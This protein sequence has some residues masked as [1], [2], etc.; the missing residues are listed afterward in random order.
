MTDRG[1][2]CPLF[3]RYQPEDLA[4]PAVLR[5]STLYVVGCLYGNTAALQTVV[6]R[7]ADEGATVMFNG[8]FH[9]LDTDPADFRLV[10]ETVA[11]H[12]AILGNV[13]AELLSEDDNGCGCAYPDY[14]DNATVELSNKIASTLALTAASTPESVDMLRG[15]PRFLVGE[16][17]GT[18]IGILHGDSESLAGWRLALEAAEPADQAIRGVGAWP[19]KPTTA[20]DVADWMTRAEV[21]VFACTHTGLPFAQDYDLPAGRRGFV[22]N[23]GRAGMPNFAGSNAGLM[24]RLSA[25]PNPPADSLYGATVEHLRLD[26]VPVS[27]DAE[28]WEHQFL[29]AWPPRTAGHTAYNGLRTLGPA[30]TVDQ[31]A[32][33][34]LTP[35]SDDLR[36]G[37]LLEEDS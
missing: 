25:D 5:C 29:A 30:L 4:G 21:A 16:I 20:A 14:I 8:D 6:N 36:S 37:D 26:A 27:Y 3:Y 24:T 1:R 19:G 22:F 7:A 11:A 28:R 33:G 23:S 15:L 13:E 2:T 10:A 18:R 35:L 12:H 17:A 31:A 9:W 32:R 34:S